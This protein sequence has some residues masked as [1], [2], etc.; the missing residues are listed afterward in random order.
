MAKK[1]TS[2]RRKKQQEIVSRGFG[3]LTIPDDVRVRDSATINGGDYENPMLVDYRDSEWGRRA[4]AK[5]T[6]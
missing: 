4:K 6:R 5:T 1:K 2:T 3:H